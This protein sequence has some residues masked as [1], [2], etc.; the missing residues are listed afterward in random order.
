MLEPARTLLAFAAVILCALGAM[1]A[2]PASGQRQPT[3]LDGRTHHEPSSDHRG[4]VRPLPRPSRPSIEV[5]VPV[6]PIDTKG[7][8]DQSRHRSQ[9]HIVG[10]EKLELQTSG[11]IPPANLGC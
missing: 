10:L 9:A 1:T 3:G 8:A 5:V 7:C 4:D 11:I 2:G 6:E